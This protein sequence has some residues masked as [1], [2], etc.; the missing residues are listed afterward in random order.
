M[1]V[2]IAISIVTIGGSSFDM[3]IGLIVIITNNTIIIIVVFINLIIISSPS[4][5]QSKIC[6]HYYYYIAPISTKLAFGFKIRI[7][8][9]ATIKFALNLLISIQGS[10]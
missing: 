10:C 1:V 2:V 6:G 7:S 5:A 3:F 9:L 8:V 4:F